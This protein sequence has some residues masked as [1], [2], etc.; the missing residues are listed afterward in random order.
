MYVVTVVPVSRGAFQGPLS[1]FSKTPATP[2]MVIEAPLRGKATPAL[3]IES[4]DAREEKLSL[5]DSAYALKKL[6]SV[7]GRRLFSASAI[8]AFEKIARFHRTSTG[9]VLSAFTPSAVSGSLQKTRSASDAEREE[10]PLPERLAFQAERAER[11]RMY[12]SLARE[13]FAK[14]ESV[15]LLAPSIVETETLFEELHRGIATQVVL[16]NSSLTKK[17]ILEAWNR[18][19]EDPEPILVIATPSFLAVPRQKVGTVIIERESARAWRGRER[20]YLDFRYAAEALATE[21]GARLIYADFPLRIETHARLETGTLEEFMRLQASSQGATTVQIVDSRK[22]RSEEPEQKKKRFSVLTDEAKRAIEI[23]LSRSGRVFIYAARKGIAPLTVCNDCGTPIIDQATGA[24]MTLHKTETGNEFIS[25]RSGARMNATISCASC[26]SWNLVSLGIGVERV[27]QE[28]DALFPS[29][30]HFHLTAD[31]ASTHA[32]AKKI[33][34]AFFDTE[35]AVLVGTERALPYLK[36]SVH[37]SV[38][39]SIDSLLS[40]SAWRSHEYAL[41]TLF[42]LKD[43]TGGLLIVQT[44][45]AESEVMKAIASSNLTEFIRHELKERETYRYPPFATFIGLSW[46]GTEHAVEKVSVLIKEKLPAYDL[47]GPLPA[48]QTGKN[49]YLAR[50]VVRFE[51]GA[52]PEPQLEEILKEMPPHI[53]ITVDPDEIV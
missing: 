13:S 27:I 41:Q 25:F 31:V 32:K 17:K 40:L 49:R 23:E 33:A 1:F 8:R 12:R 37:L 18:I 35:G 52:W 26:G 29:V 46:S 28:I 38:V 45:M 16:I 21:T 44:R 42:F 2:G 10:A 4:H 53:S 43:V 19:V 39:A 24:P 15:L 9:S 48:R 6:P 7:E 30:K 14:G 36:G 20:P 50:A 5:R 51:K 11:F 3:V 22:K 47:V 34:N